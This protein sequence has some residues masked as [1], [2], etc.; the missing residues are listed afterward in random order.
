MNKMNTETLKNVSTELTHDFKEARELRKA[1]TFKPE[2]KSY[3][4]TR[5]KQAEGI[6]SASKNILEI[7]KF[8]SKGDKDEK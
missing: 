1:N 6:I 8:L 3:F 5:C 4:M 7:E 2:D